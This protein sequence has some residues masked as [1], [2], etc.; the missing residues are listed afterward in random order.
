MNDDVL[1]RTDTQRLTR[2]EADLDILKPQVSSLQTDVQYIRTSIDQLVQRNVAHDN[3]AFPW[4]A[5]A[6]ALSIMI[7]VLG[8]FATMLT[9]PIAARTTINEQHIDE[10]VEQDNEKHAAL[11]AENAYLRGRIDE[12]SK[13]V[14][15]IDEHGSRKWNDRESP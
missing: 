1:R 3:R 15:A 13:Q 12:I 4:G 11:S 8:G 14:E 5:I 2:V 10:N 9:T 6:S 7:L